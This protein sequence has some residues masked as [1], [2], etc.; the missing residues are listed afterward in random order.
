MVDISSERNGRNVIETVVDNEGIL[1]LNK[2]HIEEELGH[3]DFREI[4][5][6]Y[7]SDDKNHRYELDN[8][9]RLHFYGQKLA[10]RVIM[11]CFL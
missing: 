6:K 2:K 8:K 7:H 5:I 1:R 9:S 10:I 3:E 11:E 4:A